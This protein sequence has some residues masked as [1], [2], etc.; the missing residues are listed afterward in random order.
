MHNWIESYERGRRDFSIAKSK[1][2]N[3]TFKLQIAVGLTRQTL[4]GLVED[5]SED[6]EMVAIL[7]IS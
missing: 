7:G 2:D 3:E 4:Q 1:N 6:P 5:F